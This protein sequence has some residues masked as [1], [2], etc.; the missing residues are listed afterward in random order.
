MHYQQ[1]AGKSLRFCCEI[2]R[3]RGTTKTT[4]KNLWKKHETIIELPAADRRELLIK[5]ISRTEVFFRD[6]RCSFHTAEELRELVQG[7][8]ALRKHIL[9][10]GHLD[11][12]ATCK[13]SPLLMNHSPVLDQQPQHD[14][15]AADQGYEP[16]TH[17]FLRTI[18]LILGVRISSYPIISA[19]SRIK[20]AAD[21]STC[22]FNP[23]VEEPF[24]N[25]EED[26]CASRHL[27]A[28]VQLASHAY[29][30][31]PAGW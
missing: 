9:Q 1:Q 2:V 25:R 8:V 31:L 21:E 29:A 16:G 6:V 30:M 5:P 20:I 12:F 19:N 10:L 14:D 26:A 28:L 7:K 18:H 11:R 15:A 22:D 24:G 23:N 13:A 3:F 17:H 27:A 4:M